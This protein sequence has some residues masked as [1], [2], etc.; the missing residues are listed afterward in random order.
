MRILPCL[1][2][3]ATLAA[4]AAAAAQAD[5]LPLRPGSI[6]VLVSRTDRGKA[7]IGRVLPGSPAQ[8]AGLGAA[9]GVDADGW[10]AGARPQPERRGT[11]YPSGDCELVAVDGRPVAG[12][13]EAHVRTALA[14]PLGS[15]V[16]VTV[17]R[18]GGAP[19][20]V[21]VA[22]GDVLGPGPGFTG[23]VATRRFVVHH[24]AVPGEAREARRLARDAERRYARSGLPRDTEGRRAHLWLHRRTDLPSAPWGVEAW[25]AH[26]WHE[27]MGYGLVE[28]VFAYLA[29]GDP[30]R[31]ARAF[32][33]GYDG[34]WGERRTAVREA[35]QSAA[36]KILQSADPVQPMPDSARIAAE[37]RSS[38][39]WGSEANSLHRYIIE[40]FGLERFR[41]LWQSDLEFERAVP[42]ALGISA[43]T[44]LPEWRAYVVGLGPDPR[45]GPSAGAVA[46]SAGW[47][48]LLLLYGA[49]AARR[50]QL[51]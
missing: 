48:A 40:R 37:G 34:R 21:R 15:S 16:E 31:A 25:A 30:G 38:T 26:A 29:W 33:P 24:R 6:G 46:V 51:G 27:P 12:W 5:P 3:L 19:R 47:G 22:R 50:R 7:G 49:H 39:T 9:C 45:A 44:L 2:A 35:H 28:G 20:T 18:G 4:P 23:V 8:A 32:L 36:R 43:H 14:G 11:R 41:R 17:R 13:S 1:A 10:P 42:Q